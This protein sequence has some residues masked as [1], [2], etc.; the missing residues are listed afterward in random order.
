MREMERLEIEWHVRRARQLRSEAL[1]EL[2]AAAAAALRQ[3]IGLAAK[4]L[5]HG[6]RHLAQGR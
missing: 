2:I 6:T 5:Q 4:R 1:G 3:R